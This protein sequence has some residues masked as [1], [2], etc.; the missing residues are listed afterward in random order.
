STNRMQRLLRDLQDITR[1]Q[2]GLGLSLEP[3]DTDLAM[4]LTQ[5]LDEQRTTYPDMQL[6]V[7]VPSS[8]P[9]HVDPIRYLQM[10]TNLLSNA[11]HHGKGRVSVELSRQDGQIRLVV[12]NP[13]EPIPAELVSS[14]F[15]PFKRSSLS[16]S[17]NPGSMGLGLYIV[18]QIVLSQG[19][20]IRYEACDGE[21]IFVL[22]IPTDA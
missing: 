12:R 8:L 15:D 21:V 6:E 19:G 14:L 16:N 22:D 3:E 17:R 13:A 20:S 11:R 2:N 5:L 1:I 7:S 4:L 9:A 18:H 10:V